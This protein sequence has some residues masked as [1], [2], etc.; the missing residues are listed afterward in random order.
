MSSNEMCRICLEEDGIFL[1]PC[2]CKG[3]Q[4]FVHEECLIKWVKES[5]RD[6]CEICKTQYAKRKVVSCNVNNYCRGI[7]QSRILS[8]VENSLIRLCP[9]HVLLGL[10]LYASSGVEMWMMISS[11]QSLMTILSLVMFQIYHHDVDY[12][13]LRVSIYW[14][15]SYLLSNIV[16]GLIRTMDNE[17][18]C[19]IHC[20]HLLKLVGCDDRCIVYNYYE[21]KAITISD[22]LMLRFLEFVILI[23]IRLLTL[24]FTHMN[25]SVYYNFSRE[26]EETDPLL[27]C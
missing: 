11:I 19:S 10:F 15:A 8:E 22:V 9:L 20:Y 26:D 5:G 14:S 23:F 21:N 2:N 27:S 12:F 3:S 1:S 16:V 25:R 4:A 6:S 18:E 24:C 13:V 17:E 7:F